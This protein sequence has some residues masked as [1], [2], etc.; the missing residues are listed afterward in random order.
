MDPNIVATHVSGLQNCSVQEDAS[1]L[2]I[3]FR[4]W[5]PSWGNKYPPSFFAIVQLLVDYGADAGN[6]A[7]EL[8]VWQIAQFE[9][10]ESLWDTLRKAE[11]VQRRVD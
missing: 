11:Q 1:P 2:E 9:G 5:R 3:L 7:N 10:H 6:I 8:D 4:S